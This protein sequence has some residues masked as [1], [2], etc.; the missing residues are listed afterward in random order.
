MTNVD[1][2]VKAAMYEVGGKSDERLEVVDIRLP[3][4]CV[5]VNRIGIG[6]RGGRE[7]KPHDLDLVVQVCI[8][9]F[10]LVDGQDRIKQMRY[11]CLQANASLIGGSCHL[12][13]KMNLRL[14]ETNIKFGCGS[15]QT[16]LN[17][18]T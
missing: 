5:S 16:I 2:K 12:N 3:C 8:F 18:E 9:T 17:I 1:E 4:T 11:T 13:D 7:A 15:C 6:P 14:P 10:H